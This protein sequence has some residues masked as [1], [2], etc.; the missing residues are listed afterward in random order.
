MN[1]FQILIG[2]TIL[3]CSAT[4]PVLYKPAAQYF[5]TKLSSAFTSTWLVIGLIAT[6][7]IFGNLITNNITIIVSSPQTLLSILKGIL[8][9]M[10]IKFQQEVN[11]E[12]TSSSVF[13]GFIALSLSSLV[14]NCFF[15]EGLSIIAL[16][17]ICG[18]GMLGTLF[19]LMGDAK[20]LSLKGRIAFTI[21]V[22]LS[23]TMTVIDHIVILKINWYP[24]LFITSL[25]MFLCC[26]VSG[27]SKQDFKNII[28]N[29]TT[30]LAG[31][32]YVISEFLVIYSSVNI[33]PVSFVSLFNRLAAPVVMLFSALKYHEQTWKNQMIFG[34]LAILLTIPIIFYK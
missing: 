2:I 15:K 21:I 5:P 9:F 10:M 32:F 14:V 8:L 22:L 24:H 16:S 23:A 28:K 11:K 31:F 12:S 27:I 34:I 19:F 20:R 30:A 7:P 1:I 26:F 17:C 6:F 4:R 18:F 29:K 3:L 33:L 25:T 13:F